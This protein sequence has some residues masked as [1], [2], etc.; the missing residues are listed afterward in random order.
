MTPLVLSDNNYITFRGII[1]MV[2]IG[3]SSEE[4]G[5]LAEAIFKALTGQ[6][7]RD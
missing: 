3:L 5:Q 1:S 7:G 6:R 4:D 2:V